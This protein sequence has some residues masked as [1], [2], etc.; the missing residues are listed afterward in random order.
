MKINPPSSRFD[1][2]SVYDKEMIIDILLD[3]IDRDTRHSGAFSCQFNRKHFVC[4]AS[5]IV[6]T[7]VCRSCMFHDAFN[8]LL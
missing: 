1:I 6:E 3:F 5:K 7:I 2:F 8:D 4:W